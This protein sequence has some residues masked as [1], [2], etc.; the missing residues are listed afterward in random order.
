MVHS[1]LLLCFAKTN[2]IFVFFICNL[3]YIRHIKVD[4]LWY[5][6]LRYKWCLDLSF[7]IALILSDSLIVQKLSGYTF[8]IAKWL[9]PRSPVSQK[10][11]SDRGS[12]TKD[13]ARPIAS[14]A[15]FLTCKIKIPLVT[16][17]V[18]VKVLEMMHNKGLARAWHIVRAQ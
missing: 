4:L 16:L 5:K 18:V 13:V 11:R 2:I 12:D 8:S 1:L 3:I 17:W 10:S 14:L 15:Q 9:K 7:Q 6:E